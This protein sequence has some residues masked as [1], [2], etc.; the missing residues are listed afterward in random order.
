MIPPLAF[1]PRRHGARFPLAAKI[2]L[3]FALNCVLLGGL[4]VVL[5]L[6]VYRLPFDVMLF[7]STRERM[8]PVLQLVEGELRDRPRE[9]WTDALARFS[10][11]YGVRFHLFD[12]DANQVAGPAV[13]L[14]PEARERLQARPRFFRRPPRGPEGARPESAENPPADSFAMPRVLLRTSRPVRYWV[15]ETM[16]LPPF[17][18]DGAPW[19]WGGFPG[20]RNREERNREERDRDGDRS[21]QPWS[22]RGASFL[23]LVIE[24]P[25]ITGNGLWLDTR[26]ILLFALG[27]IGLSLALW[28]PL[29]HGISRSIAQLAQASRRIAE[30]RFDVR[31]ADRRADELGDLAHDVNIMAQ[32]IEGLVTGQRRFLGDVAHELCSPVSRLQLSL[33]ILEQKT[34]ETDTRYVA[35]AQRNARQIAD[36]VNELL[37]FSKAA[38]G[39]DARHAEP[40][41]LRALLEEVAHRELPESMTVTLDVP[42]TLQVQAQ[43]DLLARA[44]GNLFRN[45]V[46]HAAEAPIRVSATPAP[47]GHDARILV[48]DEGPGVPED[49]LEHLFEPFY[50]LDPAR[51]A[52]TGGVGLGLAVV[53]TCI[54]S[55][56]G[57]VQA[58]NNTPHGLTVILTL[59]TATPENA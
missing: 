22:R 21:Q 34:A 58:A 12:F 2:L 47:D 56:G 59:P 30:G 29:L 14:P 45:T 20:E 40:V 31:V 28:L 57:R 11:A 4:F 23:M 7:G 41:P 51:T 18:D 32:R 17:P 19:N 37:S 42:D 44:F 33:G 36:L 24:S 46:Q 54:E 38:L 26:P 48:Q 25:S 39:G 50:R 5:V 9:E 53:K 15:F 8:R 55:C 27:G 10:E 1:P 16:A 13:D 35:S 52:A 49:A 3:W 6:T 43:P